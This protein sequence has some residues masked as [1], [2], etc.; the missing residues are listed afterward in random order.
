MLIS[1]YFNFHNIKEAHIINIRITHQLKVNKRRTV[2]HKP[3]L[4]NTMR[5]KQLAFANIK[6]TGQWQISRRSTRP[7]R[8]NS[9]L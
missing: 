3:L 2:A 7:I 6:R 8:A 9:K 5:H 4:T 1:P